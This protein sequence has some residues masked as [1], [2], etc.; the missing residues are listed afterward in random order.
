M[1][2]VYTRVLT[3]HYTFKIS[4]D[5]ENNEVNN[6]LKTVSVQGGSNHNHSSFEIPYEIFESVEQIL[7]D[8]FDCMLEK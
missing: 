2:N 8:R 4:T 6:F 3:L 7:R 1:V 5:R